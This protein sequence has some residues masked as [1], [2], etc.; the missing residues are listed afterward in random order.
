MQNPTLVMRHS[1][2]NNNNKSKKQLLDK[3]VC[4]FVA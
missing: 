3:G 1:T 4:H 2:P